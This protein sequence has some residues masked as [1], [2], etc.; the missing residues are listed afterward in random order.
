MVEKYWS[1]SENRGVNNSNTGP[2]SPNEKL[3]GK[4]NITHK[5]LYVDWG[6][7]GGVMVRNFD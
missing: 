5:T 4:H 7:F 1:E 3:N 2:E 6:T